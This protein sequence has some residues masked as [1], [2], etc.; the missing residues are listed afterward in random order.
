MGDP[1]GRFRLLGDGAF[2]TCSDAIAAAGPTIW[3]RG[4]SHAGVKNACR[5]PTISIEAFHTPALDTE[6]DSARAC[7]ISSIGC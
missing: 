3:R 5:R 7:G 6:R 2:C 4:G 1:E